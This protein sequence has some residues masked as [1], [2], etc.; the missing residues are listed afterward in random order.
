M[1]QTQVPDAAPVIEEIIPVG[2]PVMFTGR[3]SGYACFDEGY[4]AH[5]KMTYDEADLSDGEDNVTVARWDPNSREWDFNNIFNVNVNTVD[6]EITF[7]TS[8]MALYAVVHASGFRVADPVFMP[9]CNGYTGRVPTFKAIIEDVNHD[10]SP[11]DIQ[12]K[13]SGPAGDPIFTDLIIWDDG[14]DAHGWRGCYDY[15][16]NELKISLD[17]ELSWKDEWGVRAEHGLPG[18]VYTLEYVA[19][20]SVG[21]RLEKTV[22]F[23]V[24]ATPPTVEL[25][26]DV[27]GAHPVIE[28]KVN[29]MHAGLDFDKICADIYLV[30]PGADCCSG[31]IEAE[32]RLGWVKPSMMTWDPETQIIELEFGEVSFN[33]SSHGLSLDVVIF[34]CE[35]ECD[36]SA[37]EYD[38]DDCLCYYSEHGVADCVGNH[39]T[40]V[41]RR[42]TIDIYSGG[43]DVVAGI[44]D[45]YCYPNPFDVSS[46]GHAT[47]KYSL[48]GAGNLSIKIYDFAG[49]YVTT[50]HDGYAGIPGEVWWS[51]QD[52]TGRTV[53]AGAYIGSATFDDGNAVVT[54]NFKIGVIK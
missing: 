10:V 38:C 9:F 52:H 24:D 39:A 2:Y 37:Y 3:Y 11:S 1:I 35:D 36:Q 15:V 26:G 23:T 29:D 41:W 12:V 27:V 4:T 25:L 16:S 33:G 19:L 31:P 21:E 7:N 34:D 40:P 20:N 46:G 13:I 28:L 54:R 51:G 43:D 48:T 5:V 47:I 50:L 45:I 8:C 44:T 22:E 42:Y 17:S 53:G 6:N 49:E 18:G 32:E 14:D 30:Q